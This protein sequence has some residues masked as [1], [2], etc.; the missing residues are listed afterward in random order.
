MRNMVRIRPDEAVT[1]CTKVLSMLQPATASPKAT[2]PMRGRS[3]PA[4]EARRAGGTSRRV[5][6]SRLKR[7]RSRRPDA[8]ASEIGHGCIRVHRA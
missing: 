2:R 8:P 6:R 1:K 3:T 5:N 4:A 7:S